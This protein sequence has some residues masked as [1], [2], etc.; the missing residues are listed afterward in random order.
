M[1]SLHCNFNPHKEVDG[2]GEQS[3]LRT[4]LA[5]RWKVCGEAE[6]HC[7]Y[8]LYKGVKALSAVPMSIA[9]VNRVGLR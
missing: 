4:M 1:Q 3:W 7:N 6:V 8:S 9:A 5:H 2:G